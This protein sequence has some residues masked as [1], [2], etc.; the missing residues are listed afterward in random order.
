MKIFIS[1]ASGRSC[2]FAKEVYTWLESAP[3]G[4]TPWAAFNKND[5][6][7]GAD[8][9]GRI[10]EAAHSADFCLSIIADESDLSSPWIN[11]ESGLFYLKKDNPVFT[12][13]C[14]DINHSKLKQ[15]NHPLANVYAAYANEDSLLNLISAINRKIEVGKKSEDALDRFIKS[16]ATKKLISSYQ[17]I[18][19]DRNNLLNDAKNGLTD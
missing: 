5:L 15:R 7:V 16:D 10:L 6:P 11:F 2:T 12:F 8:D 3:L 13:L 18:F 14:G 9:Y 17:Q 19:S 1:Q 4:L